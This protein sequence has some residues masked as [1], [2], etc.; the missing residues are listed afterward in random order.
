MGTVIG[1]IH[2]DPEE[3]LAEWRTMTMLKGSIAWL[4]RQEDDKYKIGLE[5][6][7]GL[8]KEFLGDFLK[9]PK[10]SPFSQRKRVA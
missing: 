6:E 8:Y 2:R 9:S 1:P 3:R 4:K 10:V 5:R 7:K